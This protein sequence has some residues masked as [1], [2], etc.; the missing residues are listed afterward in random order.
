[1]GLDFIKCNPLT[2][3]ISKNKTIYV[4][5]F[6]YTIYKRTGK[7]CQRS[8]VAGICIFLELASFIKVMAS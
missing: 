5:K 7:F 8:L 4:S 1:M 6:L 2:H 3:S